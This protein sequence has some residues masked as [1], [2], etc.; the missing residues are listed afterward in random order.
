MVLFYLLNPRDS[1]HKK[2]ISSHYEGTKHLGLI[3][4]P[5]VNLLKF[6]FFSKQ[7]INNFHTIICFKAYTIY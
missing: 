7:F 3:T 5:Y 2:T 4:L 6:F 1:S